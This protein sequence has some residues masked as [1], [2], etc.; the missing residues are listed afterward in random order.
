M[1]GSRNRLFWV[2]AKCLTA[3]PASHVCLSL[4]GVEHDASLYVMASRAGD[5]HPYSVR[6]TRVILPMTSG[7]NLV[8]EVGI[9]PDLVGAYETPVCTSSTSPQ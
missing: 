3:R 2:E 8:A 6:R 4:V 9:E 5:S 1:R 7:R